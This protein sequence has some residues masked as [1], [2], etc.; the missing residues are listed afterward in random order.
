[1]AKH[2]TIPRQWVLFRSAVSGDLYISNQKGTPIY[3]LE[4]LPHYEGAFRTIMEAQHAGIQII[5][6]K[7]ERLNQQLTQLS[8]QAIE[9]QRNQK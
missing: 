7:M 8:D 4:K 5:R 6:Y 1:M 2:K 3:E 9:L